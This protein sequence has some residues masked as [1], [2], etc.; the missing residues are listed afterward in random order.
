MNSYKKYTNRE[1]NYF[2]CH[3]GVPEKDFNCMFCYCP[4]Y[5][6][7]KECGG[8]FEYIANIKD[9]SNCLLPHLK[10]GYEFIN[11]KIKEALKKEV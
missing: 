7:G 8:N 6:L 10:N 4:L 2:P 3:K 5:F 11:D 1:C 9:C